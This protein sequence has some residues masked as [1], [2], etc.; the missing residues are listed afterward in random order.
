[1]LHETEILRQ[2]WERNSHGNRA[3]T[4]VVLSEFEPAAVGE[5]HPWNCPLCPKP[6]GVHRGGLRTT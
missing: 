4:N 3:L 2:N 1:M 6:G 5:I